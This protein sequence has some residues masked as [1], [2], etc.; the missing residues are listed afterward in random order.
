MFKIWVQ[1]VGREDISH[2]KRRSYR[3][4]DAH[5]TEEMKFVAHRNR[6]NLCANAIPMLHL[7][8]GYLCYFERAV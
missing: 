5:F 2:D 6:T 1:R 4:C 3:I 8:G 7:R